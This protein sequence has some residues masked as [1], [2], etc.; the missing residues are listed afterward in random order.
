M[1]RLT[2]ALIVLMLAFSVVGCGGGG[3]DPAAAP[4][5]GAPA[6]DPGAVEGSTEASEQVDPSDPAPAVTFEPFPEQ[7]ELP[8]T[9]AEDLKSR[10]P[11]LLLF[12]DGSQ[13]VTNE[14]RAAVDK[15]MAAN[16]GLVN[17]YV[18]DIGKYTTVDAK[19]TAVV[20]EARLGKDKEGRIAVNLARDL[21]VKTTP[22][23]IMTDDQGFIVFRHSGP[24]DAAFLKMHMERL[25]E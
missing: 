16:R 10:Q 18:Y 17:L 25:T 13:K 21:A 22:Y 19:G 1:R 8:A 20:D 2:V 12:V 11:T 15:A 7:V 4:T 9:L 14:V 24:T 3:D 5:D 6:T 23:I